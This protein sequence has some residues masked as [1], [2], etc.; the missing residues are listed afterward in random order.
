MIYPTID[1]SPFA[2][3]FNYLL[4]FKISETFPSCPFWAQ[5]DWDM[6]KGKV[7]DKKR[8]DDQRWNFRRK[9]GHWVGYFPTPKSYNKVGLEKDWIILIFWGGLLSVTP[10][11]VA[12]LDFHKLGRS[13][14]VFP[15]FFFNSAGDLFKRLMIHVT[16]LLV[17]DI[18]LFNWSGQT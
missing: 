9:S 2:L 13:P 7:N 10:L 15:F 16:T 14:L 8:R 18:H 17:C 12:E 4:L 11:L 6:W 1:P 3:F 5:Y